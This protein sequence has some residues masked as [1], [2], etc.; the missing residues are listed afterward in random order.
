MGEDL[1]M[2]TDTIRCVHCGLP[3]RVAIGRSSV[4]DVDTRLDNGAIDRLYRL[5]DAVASCMVNGEPINPRR[6]PEFLSC[7]ELMNPNLLKEAPNE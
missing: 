5:V 3:I 4:I 7:M 2:R 6:M 1:V